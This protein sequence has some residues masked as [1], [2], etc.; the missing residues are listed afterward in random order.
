ML[1]DLF[2][3]A[4]LLFDRLLLFAVAFYLLLHFLQHIGSIGATGLTGQFPKFR[5]GMRQY[6]TEF[7]QS[8]FQAVDRPF[9]FL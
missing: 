9:C 6:R 1:F 2:Q 7:L 3:I 4:L 8:A 5:A